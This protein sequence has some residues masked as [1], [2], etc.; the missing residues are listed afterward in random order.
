VDRVQRPQRRLGD[1][2]GGCEQVAVERQQGER[3]EQLA[4]TRQQSLERQP[5]LSCSRP[6]DRAWDLG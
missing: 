4:G 2:S 5:R 6:P 1:R 3:V